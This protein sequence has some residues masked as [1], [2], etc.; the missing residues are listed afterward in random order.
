MY[1]HVHTDRCINPSF[2]RV[3]NFKFPLQPH[4]E[5]YITQCLELAFH[6]L[7]I[8]KIDDYT[9]PILTTWPIHFSLGRLG[10][11]A[12][13]TCEWNGVKPP[14]VL[15]GC[16]TSFC[17]RYNLQGDPVAQAPKEP[18]RTIRWLSTPKWSRLDTPQSRGR[19]CFHPKR[20]LRRSQISWES[21]VQH[22][23]GTSPQLRFDSFWFDA[24]WFDLFLTRYD[25]ISFEFDL[26]RF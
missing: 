10:E 7:L 22:H 13:W 4:Q 20:I 14:T 3:I 18:Y 1:A 9:I 5:Y 17:W 21:R 19:K 2:P 25:S 24:T 23:A 26:V 12:F 11:C 16:S 8:W 15:Q 6:N